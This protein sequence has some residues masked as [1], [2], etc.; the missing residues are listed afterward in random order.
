MPKIEFEVDALNFI[1]VETVELVT[2]I[3]GCVWIN[4]DRVCRLRVKSAAHVVV[5]AE[6]GTKKS[7]EALT[8]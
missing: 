3:D 1:D 2:S 4:I 8:R 6:I 5:N 7:K